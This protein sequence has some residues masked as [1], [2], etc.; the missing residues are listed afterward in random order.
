MK[1]ALIAMSGG[2]DSSAAAYLMKEKGYDCCGVTMK[3][4]DSM[5][6]ACGEGTCCSTEDIE[7][8]RSVCG[9]LGIIHETV[10]FMADFEECVIIPFIEDYEN[11]R[12]PNPC[13]ECNRKLKFGRLF[14]LAKKRG[15][16]K[17]ATGHY[18]RVSYD[19]KSGRWQLKKALDKFKD[20]SYVL[21]TLTQEELSF[22]ELPNGEYTKDSIREVAENRGFVNARKKDSQDICFIPDGDYA[23]FLEERRGGPYPEGKFVDANGNVLG[24]HK[25]IIHYTVGQRKGL[26]ISSTEPYYVIQI[27]PKTNE[28]VLGR[29]AELQKTKVRAT[30]FNWV[31]ICSPDKEVRCLGKIRYSHKGETGYAKALDDGTVEMNFDNPVYGVSPG[32]A[33]VLYEGDLV[34][35]GGTI[36]I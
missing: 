32:Q 8:A 28:V 25:G 27:N 24:K 7:D 19:E 1:K 36:I 11:A 5:A 16:E 15:F 31:S 2:V 14:E 3:L 13:I 29:K 20:Q 22:L 6:L 9:K 4:Y 21:Y 18:A 17:V 34:L 23:R 12:T 33:L 10:D 35:G 30:N 26:G